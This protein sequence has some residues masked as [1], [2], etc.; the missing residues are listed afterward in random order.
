M[1][2]KNMFQLKKMSGSTRAIDDDAQINR[3]M[4]MQVVLCKFVTY[5][6]VNANVDFV[7]NR[8]TEKI[9]VDM[10]GRFYAMCVTNQG[11]KQSIMAVTK[12]W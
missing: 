10:E 9:R 3:K 4:N 7:E 1:M 2:V 6:V 11:T 8:T 12:T 5:L